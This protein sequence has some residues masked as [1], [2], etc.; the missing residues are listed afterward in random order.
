MQIKHF[1][2][3]ELVVPTTKDREITYKWK[4]KTQYLETL[5]HTGEPVGV[6][7]LLE[8]GHDQRNK[9]L[10]AVMRK[11]HWNNSGTGFEVQ[12]ISPFD[13]VNYPY[14]TILREPITRYSEK[15]LKIFQRKALIALDELTKTNEA[16]ASLVKL[17]TD[18]V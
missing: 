1:R 8:I 9:Q 10:T 14:L 5:E 4:S 7:V 16:V 13:K 12:F 6:M 15:A 18:I 11:V 2:V 3:H 17:A